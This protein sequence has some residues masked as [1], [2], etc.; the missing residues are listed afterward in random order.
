MSS[1]PRFWGIECGVNEPNIQH[2]QDSLILVICLTWPKVIRPKNPLMLYE[3]KNF[4]LVY[5]IG[6]RSAIT[7]RSAPNYLKIAVGGF[8][9]KELSARSR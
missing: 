9:F 1:S 8:F 3:A 5:I 4:M 7:H 6:L 2:S